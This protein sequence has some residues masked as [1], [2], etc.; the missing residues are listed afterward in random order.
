MLGT[1][2]EVM[3]GLVMLEMEGQ[4][5]K[6][7]I[8]MEREGQALWNGAMQ[9]I[10]GQV[11][12]AGAIRETVEQVRQEGLMLESVGQVMRSSL[13]VMDLSSTLMICPNCGDRIQK[14]VMIFNRLR[15]VRVIC[16]CKKILREERL[17]K[18]ELQ[19]RKER[20]EGLFKNSLMEK[21]F[22][23][24]TFENWDLTKGDKKYH[25]LGRKYVENFQNVKD[26][27]LGLI[28]YGEVGSGKSY[29]S[30]A[31]ANG[32]LQNYVS[33]V[34]ISINGLLDRIKETYNR[35]GSEGEQEVIKALNN[36]ELLI[37]D[38]LG[39]E[40]NTEWSIS[41]L[42]DIIDNRYR[43]NLPIIITT[44]HSMEELRIKYGIRTVDRLNE[45]CINIE[46][47]G[48]SLRKDKGLEN[49]NIL[50]GILREAYHG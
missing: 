12:Q 2:E 39:V 47:K 27:G 18:Q 32:L 44:N 35:W 29:L 30:F 6:G 17:K 14:E 23:H 37:I 3:K 31:I 50:R 43:N 46:Y 42:Y 10:M 1:V 25:T 45:V 28:I 49:V 9:E 8:I 40:K 22:F 19:E 24:K 48:R 34:C 38:D 26:K 33:V 4:A 5:V 41:K 20:L 15:K 11:S 13:D 16:S 7:A 21:S 36:A